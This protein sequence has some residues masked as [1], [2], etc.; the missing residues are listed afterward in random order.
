MDNQSS[1]LMV[2]TLD[3]KSFKLIAENFALESWDLHTEELVISQL[4]LKAK[5]QRHVRMI[6]KKNVYMFIHKSFWREI[7]VHVTSQYV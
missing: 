7:T 1:T 4:I 2:T 3:L 5:P 6:H